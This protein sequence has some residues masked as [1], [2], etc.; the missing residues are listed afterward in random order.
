MRQKLVDSSTSKRTIQV[1]GNFHPL[2]RLLSLLICDPYSRSL[3]T[4]YR[5]LILTA[6]DFLFST[7]RQK[8]I[9]CC[10]ILLQKKNLYQFWPV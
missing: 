4:L 1:P 9:F 2:L 6:K 3:E 7:L 5:H 10:R 8:E